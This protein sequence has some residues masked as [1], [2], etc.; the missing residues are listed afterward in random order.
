[1]TQI[2]HGEKIA[3]AVFDSLGIEDCEKITFTDGVNKIRYDD[4]C[5]YVL[6]PKETE[7]DDMSVELTLSPF[8]MMRLGKDAV[9]AM[10]EDKLED[11]I[12]VYDM[13]MTPLRVEGDSVVYRCTITD[14][15]KLYNVSVSFLDVNEDGDVTT[16]TE[17][18]YEIETYNEA[19][20]L[21]LAII[22]ARNSDNAAGVNS[23]IDVEIL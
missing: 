19:K 1:M 21:E 10:V 14:F 4:L 18:M 17:D 3:E 2:V 12:S 7:H 11:K 6:N 8:E 15:T 9:Y 22:R 5:A 23:S 16:I 20:A 13:D